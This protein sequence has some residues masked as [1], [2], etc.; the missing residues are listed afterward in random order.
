MLRRDAMIRF[1]GQQI[2]L[3]RK[4]PGKESIAEVQNQQGSKLELALDLTKA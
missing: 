4:I 2:N 1:V 3:Q